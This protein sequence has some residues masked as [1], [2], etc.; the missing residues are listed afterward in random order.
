M[1]G[2]VIPYTL[3]GGKGYFLVLEEG[4]AILWDTGWREGCS[5]DP[6]W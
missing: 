1:E 2:G 5:L 3:G 6:G 4:E